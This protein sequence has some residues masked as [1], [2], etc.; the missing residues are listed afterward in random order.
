MRQIDALLL[1]L[2]GG[3]A[4]VTAGGAVFGEPGQYAE[5]LLAFAPEH[6]GEPAIA[7]IEPDGRLPILGKVRMPRGIARG[8]ACDGRVVSWAVAREPDKAGVR[9]ITLETAPAYRRRG[10]AKACL[11]ALARE[12][13]APLLYLCVQENEH[14][15]KTALSAGFALIGTVERRPMGRV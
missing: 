13:E 4:R 8:V 15:A 14:S 11:Q 12:V 9:H 6:V 3:E 7:V 1:F 5:K 10:F 2:E